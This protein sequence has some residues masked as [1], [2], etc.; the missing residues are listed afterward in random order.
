MPKEDLLTVDEVAGE[1]RITP[2]TV[3]ALVNS[4]RLPAIRV[5]DNR[6]PRLRFRRS[7]LDAWLEERMVGRR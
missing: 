4:G 7:D 6:E 3:R 5:M 1:L 2:R